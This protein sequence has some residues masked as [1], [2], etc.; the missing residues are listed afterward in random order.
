MIGN[1]LRKSGHILKPSVIRRLVNLYPP[2]VGAGIRMTAVSDNF[3]HL[4]VE[5]PL[6]WY[7][8][9]F[10]GTQ[11]GGSIYAMTDPFYMMM[12]IQILGP[13]YIVWDK[14][15]QIEFIAP[16]RRRLIVEF[17]WT[18]AE[19]E[20]VRAVTSNGQKYLFDR[21]VLVRDDQDQVVAR[22]NKTLYVRKKELVSPST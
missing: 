2:F 4:R 8:A 17:H 16:G 1:W 12:L 15:A 20:K 7:N 9:N 19:I 3:H 14:A 5:L 21:E 22:V 11:F 10:V 6:T 13:D 18:E